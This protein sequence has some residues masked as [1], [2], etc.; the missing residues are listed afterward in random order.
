MD[1]DEFDARAELISR[2]L[3]GLS[4]REAIGILECVKLV[5]Y[6]TQEE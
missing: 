1:N 2:Q 6:T 4:R 5:V 3:A